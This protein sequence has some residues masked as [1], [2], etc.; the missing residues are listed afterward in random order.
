MTTKTP[1]ETSLEAISRTVLK[2]GEL[3]SQL[4]AYPEWQVIHLD[5]TEENATG[6]A[7]MHV[8]KRTWKFSNF[9]SA[10]EFIQKVTELAETYNHH[11]RCVLEWGSASVIWWSHDLGGVTTSDLQ[12]A[13]LCDHIRI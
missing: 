4:L 12:M 1:S 13:A 6:G 8:I 9:S 5:G 3:E 7:G 10:F 11:P 2:G